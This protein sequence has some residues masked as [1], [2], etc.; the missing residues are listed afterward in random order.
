MFP[1]VVG[2]TARDLLTTYEE[3]LRA[4][5]HADDR[6]RWLLHEASFSK[7]IYVAPTDEEAWADIEPPSMRHLAHFQHNKSKYGRMSP[8][9]T[10][11]AARVD[12]PPDPQLAVDLDPRGANYSPVLQRVW[13]S[14]RRRPS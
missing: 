14:A 2:H 10:S 13:L 5:G 1:R 4:G 12:A 9:P 6:V 11:V 3:A 8:A 7:S